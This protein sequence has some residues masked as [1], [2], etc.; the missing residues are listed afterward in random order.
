MATH[1]DTN[2]PRM[3]L[4]PAAA[5]TEW[6]RAMTFGATKYGDHN[7]RKG[8]AWTRVLGSLSRH[9][10]S[11]MAGED[12]DPESGVNHMAH[13]MCNAAFLLHY[14]KHHPELDDRYRGLDPVPGRGLE[15]SPGTQWESF[16]I[17]PQEQFLYTFDSAEYFQ[18]QLPNHWVQHYFPD[19][20]VYL[21]NDGE[22]LAAVLRIYNDGS[23]VPNN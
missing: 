10:T 11:F 22:E 20:P 19:T 18:A 21:F 17:G 5:L 12:R 9:L 14:E 16:H 7:W 4:L 15:A 6:A 13:V 8:L 1:L 3:E 2:K 23:H